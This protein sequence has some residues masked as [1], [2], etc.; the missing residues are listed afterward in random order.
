VENKNALDMQESPKDDKIPDN[1]NVKHNE[2]QPLPKAENKSDL[3]KR[4]AMIVKLKTMT[5]KLQ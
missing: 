1:D 3:E 4:M 2:N 5:Y